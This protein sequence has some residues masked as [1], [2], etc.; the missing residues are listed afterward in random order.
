M[1][2][3]TDNG[4][5][6]IQLDFDMEVREQDFFARNFTPVTGAFLP[7]GRFV[8]ASRD[9]VKLFHISKAGAFYQKSLENGSDVRRV[10]ILPV[11]DRN[12]CAILDAWG[13]IRVYEI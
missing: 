13:E 12:R 2:A 5:A 8:V 7:G 4:C 11:S 6:L 10:A 1:V 3:L 9:E